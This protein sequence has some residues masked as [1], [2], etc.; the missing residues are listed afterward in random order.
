[1]AEFVLAE[2]E[3]DIEE[4]AALAKEI[5][6]EHYDELLGVEQVDYMTDKLQSKE[7]LKEQ[8]KDGYEYYIIKDEGKSTGYI[9]IHQEDTPRLFLS[10]LYIRKEFRGKGLSSRAFEFMEKLCRERGLKSIWLT[11]NKYNSGSIAVYE[12]RGFK[13]F[14]SQ[15]TDIGGGYVMDDYFMELN[16]E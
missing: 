15:V 7:A 5:W 16:V 1:M 9:G 11:V 13:T 6:H 14:D 3:K 8:I 12:H 2:N 10:K 4:V